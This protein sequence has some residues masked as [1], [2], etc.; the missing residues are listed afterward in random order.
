MAGKR[1]THTTS[2]M[3]LSDHFPVVGSRSAASQR[4]SA[5]K[6]STALMLSA[7]GRQSRRLAR[8][9]LADANALAVVE[10]LVA[11]HDGLAAAK[12]VDHLDPVARVARRLDAHGARA[13]AVHHEDDRVA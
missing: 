7:P 2:K 11:D 3:P 8:S 5:S 10:L 12:A 13:P 9:A 1:A 4:R 6:R